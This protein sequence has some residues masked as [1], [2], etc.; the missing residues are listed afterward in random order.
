MRMDRHTMPAAV[1]VH[2]SRDI[3]PALSSGERRCNIFLRKARPLL[4]QGMAKDARCRC[5]AMAC[6]AVD[7][8]DGAAG[9]EAR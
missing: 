4:M 8:D 5:M 1:G 3:V 9:P 2:G 7:L 6:T